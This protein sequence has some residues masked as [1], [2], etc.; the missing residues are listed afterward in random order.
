MISFYINNKMILSNCFVNWSTN[1]HPRIKTLPFLDSAQAGP[2]ENVQNHFSRHLRS[3]EIATTIVY[4]KKSLSPW[5]H[6]LI[7]WFLMYTFVF[8]ISQVLR[9]LQGVSK[10]MVQCLFWKY[11]GNQVFDFQS[12]FFSW[13]L[14]SIC[15]FWIQNH[16]CVILGSWEI[17]K[18]K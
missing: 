4:T 1:S 10:K 16:F 3:W 13:K 17:C 14:R 7:P 8:A 2:L 18:T 11:L 5:L 9:Y 15:K 12:V 6:A